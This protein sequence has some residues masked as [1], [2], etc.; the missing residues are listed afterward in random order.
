MIRQTAPVECATNEFEVNRFYER[1]HLTH[2][3]SASARH[4]PCATELSPGKL[5]GDARTTIH[6]ISW[7]SPVPPGALFMRFIHRQ[8]ISKRRTA[9][10][11]KFAVAATRLS[12]AHGAPLWISVRSV[13]SGRYRPIR[14]RIAKSNVIYRRNFTFAL[15]SILA[16]TDFNQCE[17]RADARERKKKQ[18]PSS[19]E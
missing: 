16:S 15:D 1:N 13:H 6:A 2:C 18:I 14:F 17:K 3:V 12:G 8:Y 11:V 19:P 5:F 7:Y 4:S 10:E 9:L